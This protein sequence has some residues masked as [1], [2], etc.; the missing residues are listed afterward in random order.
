MKITISNKELRA[1]LSDEPLDFPKYTT[2]LL[3]LA[4]Q[5]AGG[6][7]PRV[8]GQ[9]T[10]LIQ[11]FDGRTLSEWEAWYLDRHPDALATATQRIA[12]MVENLKEALGKI[13]RALIEQ[14]VRDLVVVKTFIGLRCQE[15]ILRKVAEARGVEWRLAAPEEEARGI[16]GF[17]GDEAVSI[18]PETY[19]IEAALPEVI[20][21]K[22]IRYRKSKMVSWWSLTED[23]RC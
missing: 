17:I 14:W 23:R 16:D 2:R 11:R 21:V 15:A 10:E 22:F 8:V 12:Q 5:L 13:D 20:S 1:I 18:K 19:S 9:M 4:N 6:T 3:N 7:R